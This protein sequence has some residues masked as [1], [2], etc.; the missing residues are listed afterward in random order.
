MRCL[1]FRSSRFALQFSD[2]FEQKRREVEAGLILVLGYEIIVGAASKVEV[3][4]LRNGTVVFSQVLEYSI[5]ILYVQALAF[6]V[7]LSEVCLQFLL[8]LLVNFQN[9]RLRH[10][11]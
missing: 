9:L 4:H 7:F 3:D 2:E 11:C 10:A 8:G 1:K 5:I 6:G